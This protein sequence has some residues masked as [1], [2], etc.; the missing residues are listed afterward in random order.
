M[1]AAARDGG[2]YLHDLRENR[3][4]RI[5]GTVRQVLPSGQLLGWSVS[6]TGGNRWR[7]ANLAF[8]P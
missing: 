1:H 6:S 4:V 8:L 7:L 2:D 5:A 3:P